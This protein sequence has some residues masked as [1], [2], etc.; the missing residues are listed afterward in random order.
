MIGS[1]EG[2]K[3]YTHKA[4]LWSL[5]KL[6]LYEEIEEWH[7][8]NIKFVKEMNERGEELPSLKYVL[9]KK[10]D[11]LTINL[12]YDENGVLVTGA[13]RGTGDN[14]RR[15]NSSSQNYKSHTS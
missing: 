3:K 14:W 9:T 12:T 8:R 13:T 1:L 4:R 7:N 11:G 15:C 2:F 5:E 10:F 6:K